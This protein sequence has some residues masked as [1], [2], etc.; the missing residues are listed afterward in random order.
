MTGLD[1]RFGQIESTEGSQDSGHRYYPVPL[2]AV[3]LGHLQHISSVRGT[4]LTL[5]DYMVRRNQLSEF[6]GVILCQLLLD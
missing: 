4:V 5:L 3:S 1:E 2:L 6:W